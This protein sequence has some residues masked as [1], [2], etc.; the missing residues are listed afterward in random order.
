MKHIGIHVLQNSRLTSSTVKNKPLWSKPLYHWTVLSKFTTLSDSVSI[1]NS[2]RLLPNFA[3]E[4]TVVRLGL[5]SIRRKK[6]NSIFIFPSP[7]IKKRAQLLR[8]REC[9]RCCRQE[10]VKEVALSGFDSR[11]TRINRRQFESLMFGEDGAATGRDCWMTGFSFSREQRFC[12]GYLPPQ[13]PILFGGSGIKFRFRL[14]F[15]IIIY[16]FIIANFKLEIYYFY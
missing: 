11:G 2:P 15:I 10:D 12:L 13:G 1:R 9:K 14:H 6:K 7:L 8:N 4:S 16:L 3:I 5:T